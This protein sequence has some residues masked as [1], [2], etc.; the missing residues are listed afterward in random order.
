MKKKLSITLAAVLSSVLLLS[1]CSTGGNTANSGNS[2]AGNSGS[3]EKVHLTFTTWGDVNSSSSEQKLADEFN[4]S[5]PN[6]E[7]KFEPVPGD[8]YATKLT[9]SLA[10]GTAP[11][12]FLIGEGDFYAYV[13]KGVV[14]PLDDYVAKDSSF[15]LK[16]YQQDLIDMERINDKL[17]YLPKDFNPLALWYNKR[18]FD[19]A[20][21]AYPSDEWTWDDLIATAQKLTKQENNKYTQFGFNAGTWEYPIYTYLWAYG[22]DIANEEGTK[23]E[24][25][26]N[27][28]KTITAI[29]KYVDLSTGPNRV[30]PTPQDTETMGG[31]SSMFMTDKLAM[32]VTGR[33]I[34]S[35]L[36]KS[37]VEYGSALIP[38]GP[39][40]DRASIIAAAGWAMN[41]K[42]KHKEEAF[43]L[44]KWLSGTDAQKLRSK[45]GLVLPAT[46]TELEEVKA[47][48]E[49]DKPVIEMMS[50]ARKPVTMRSAN[51]PIF[52][53]AFTQALEK[54]LVGKVDVK[55]ALDEAAKTAD[56][57][58]K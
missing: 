58:I 21:I 25:F 55:S 56:S 41:S 9:T 51:G 54:I 15:D 19:E 46:T 3:K 28:E 29:Q 38:K 11:D 16:M 10:S 47:T 30:S 13:D 23:A 34:K 24:G 5:H 32:M 49:K 43:E 22:T 27:S 35:D 52:K 39:N 12:V 33:W 45:D 6:I 50:F 8:G 44:M 18:I 53:D 42:T 2:S 17:Y 26:M 48:E 36:D 1:A 40:G 4:A 57:K 37:N 31:D 14:E 20:G 7:V